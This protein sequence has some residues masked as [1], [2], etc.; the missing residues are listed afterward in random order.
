[1]AYPLGVEFTVVVQFKDGRRATL[2]GGFFTSLLW[3]PA[4]LWGSGAWRYLAN[5]NGKGGRRWTARLIS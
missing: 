4:L 3:W 1:M 5:D 2:G